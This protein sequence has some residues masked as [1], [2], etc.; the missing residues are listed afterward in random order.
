MASMLWIISEIIVFSVFC[1]GFALGFIATV[2]YG[3]K[4]YK[5][6]AFKKKFI[7]SLIVFLFCWFVGG[8]VMM[9]M[10]AL[11]WLAIGR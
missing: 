4:Y 1:L 9:L 8:A 11:D 7:Y 10:L 3:I 2:Y 5:D 6:K